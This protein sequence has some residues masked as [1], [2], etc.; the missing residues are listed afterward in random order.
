VST[1][2]TGHTPAR[3]ERVRSGVRDEVATTGMAGVLVV[4]GDDV[5]RAE[6][7]SSATAAGVDVIEH[8]DLSMAWS[9]WT[10]AALVFLGADLGK[11]TID[12]VLPPAP[13]VIIVARGT[14]YPP[15]HLA[16]TLGAAYVAILPTARTWLTE[17]IRRAA[18]T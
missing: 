5:I 10:T 2:E 13:E 3:P 1:A 12:A 4:S 16:A 11:A 7:R 6:I 9:D 17:R 15:F 18:R 14:R 8:T